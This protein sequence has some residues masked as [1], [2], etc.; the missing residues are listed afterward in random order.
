MKH[1]EQKSELEIPEV[2]ETKNPSRNHFVKILNF[3]N[4]RV[5]RS[6]SHSEDIKF[7][8]LSVKF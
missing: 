7:Y 3:Y 5:K 6:N 1:P 4:S 2:C 8:C